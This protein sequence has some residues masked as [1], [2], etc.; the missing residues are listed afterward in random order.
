MLSIPTSIK[1]HGESAKTKYWL[2]PF[3]AKFVFLWILWM[4]NFFIQIQLPQVLVLSLSGLGFI[5]SCW[6]LATGHSRKINAIS[7]IISGI[8]LQ[9]ILFWGGFYSF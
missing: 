5:I 1:E 6:E 8:I 4:G 2:S 3:L 7:G 9:G